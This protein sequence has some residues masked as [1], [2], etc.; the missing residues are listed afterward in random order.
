[1]T[2]DVSRILPK[3]YMGSRPP[4][5]GEVR[6]AGFD[7]LVLC[8]YELQLPRSDFPGVEVLY[9]PL[10]DDSSKPVPIDAWSTVVHIAARVARR[11]QAGK[12][13]LVTCAMGLNRSGVVAASTVHFLTGASGAEAATWVQRR[14][15][16]GGQHALYNSAFVKALG[17]RLPAR[18]QRALGA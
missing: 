4:S 6:L 15:V 5:G 14:R 16:V 10:E 11:V 18:R 8:A 2:L 13:A 9:A 3:L 1:M 17:A 7:V 12:R